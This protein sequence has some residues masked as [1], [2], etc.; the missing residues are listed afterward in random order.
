M[1]LKEVLEKTTKFFKEKNIESARLDSEMLISKALGLTRVELYMKYEQPLKQSEVELCREYVRRRILGE[2]VA[3][4]LGHRDFYRLNFKVDSRVLIPRPET[5]T[6]VEF[7]LNR[8]RDSKRDNFEVL[9]LGCGSGCIG[10]SIA[11]HESRAHVKMLDFSFDAIEVAKINQSQLEL[12]EATEVIMAAAM[13][14]EPGTQKFDFIVSNPPYISKDDP[15]VQ[16]EVKKFEPS[17]ALFSGR[18][19]FEDI[20]L[21]SQKYASYLNSGGCMIFEVGYTQGEKTKAHFESLNVFESVT[22]IQDFSGLDRFVVGVARGVH[23]G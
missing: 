2:P 17:S 6:L 22:I 19:G 11:K 21:W 5:E 16:A 3:Y 4:I 13:E 1:I 18:D 8:M 15:N 12:T 20:F 14:F 10:L 23:N 7:V 9:D